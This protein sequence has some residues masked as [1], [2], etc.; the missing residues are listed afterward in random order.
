MDLGL[1]M[2]CSQHDDNSAGEIKVEV[3]SRLTCRIYRLVHATLFVLIGVRALTY[4]GLSECDIYIS[5]VFVAVKLRDN[6]NDGVRIVSLRCKP[7]I[8]RYA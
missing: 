8:T 2:E 3:E 4:H 5:H 7:S 6:D 1:Y